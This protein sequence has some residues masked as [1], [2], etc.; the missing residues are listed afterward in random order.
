[1]KAKTEHRRAQPRH[2]AM[3]ESRRDPDAPPPAAS[4]KQPTAPA[5][6]GG[7]PNW[8]FGTCARCRKRD[9]LVDEAGL[10][11]RTCEEEANRT[12]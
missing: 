4:V 3:N 8:A 7:R 9:F 5:S 2:P 10:V 11:C 12:N 1:M 6:R